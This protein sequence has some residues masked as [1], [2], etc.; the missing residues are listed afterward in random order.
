MSETVENR[1]VFGLHGI[2]GALIA[3]VLLLSILAG[4]TVWG[5]VVQQEQAA[6]Y[7][8]IKNVEQLTTINEGKTSE[9]FIVDYAKK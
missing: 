6:N 9:D 2:G 4:L 1:N 5:L 8:E 3:V 7:Y